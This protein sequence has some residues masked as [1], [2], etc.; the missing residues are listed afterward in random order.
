MKRTLLV[1]LTVTL[2]A[3]CALGALVAEALPSAALADGWLAPGALLERLSERLDLTPDQQAEFRATLAAHGPEITGG[4]AAIRTSRL[5]LFAAIHQHPYSEDD[6]R[7]A[8]ARLAGAQAELAVE[9][10]EIVSEVYERLTPEQRAELEHLERD[11]VTLVDAVASGLVA[12]FRT[13]LGA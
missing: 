3:T 5:D 6:V 12:A 4:L 13:R 8:A 10:A 11:A 7:A 1:A 9:R 2:V